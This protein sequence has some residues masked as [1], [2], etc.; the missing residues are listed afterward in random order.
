MKVDKFM[1]TDFVE[2][3]IDNYDIKTAHRAKITHGTNCTHSF[4]NRVTNDIELIDEVAKKFVEDKNLE[5][6]DAGNSE[7][8]NCLQQANINH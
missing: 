6:A 2:F 3:L 1:L 7:Y 4:T 8:L 5:L